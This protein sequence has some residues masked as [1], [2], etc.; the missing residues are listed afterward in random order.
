MDVSA[1]LSLLAVKFPIVALVLGVLG[2]LV[3]AGQAIV[4]ITPSK[5]DDE[6]W[7][8]LKKIPV[9]GLIIAAVAD[10]APIQ[11]K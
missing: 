8:R 3:V 11:R 5:S 1:I 10:F 6:F 2:V 7:D 4:V 9:L